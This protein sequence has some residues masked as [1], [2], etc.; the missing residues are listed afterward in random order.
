MECPAERKILL[1][2]GM[3]VCLTLAAEVQYTELF[4][5]N[6]VLCRRMPGRKKILLDLGLLVCLTL[7]AEVQYTADYESNHVWCGGMQNRRRNLIGFGIARMFDWP[8]LCF[9]RAYTL[10]FVLLCSCSI[11]LC[12]FCFFCC[13]LVH[14][15][16][17]AKPVDA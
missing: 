5:S 8:P 15:K 3:L 9:V 14:T 2:L 17:R 1:D 13:S 6:R 7:A 10:C 16:P 12:H 11:L 4:E